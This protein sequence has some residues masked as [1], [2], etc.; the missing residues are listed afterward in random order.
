MILPWL[1]VV[2]L[3]VVGSLLTLLVA[4]L[5]VV[6]AWLWRREDREDLFREYVLLL[7][8][9]FAVLAVSRSV[10]H[11]VKQGLLL[12]D[13]QP[14]WLALS[15]YSGAVNTVSFV[16]AYGVSLSFQRFQTVN[17]QLRRH[18]DQLEAI[19]AERTAT[20]VDTN[21]HLAEESRARLQAM[22]QLADE[23]QRLTVTLR[24]I[25]DGVIATDTA[26]TVVLLNGIAEKLCGWEEKDA[27]GRPLTEVFQ[28]VDSRS[29][30]TVTNPVETVLATGELVELAN[31]V[32]LIS[33][34]G[35]RYRIADSGAPIVDLDEMII[36]AVLVFR[37]VSEKERLEEEAFR[38]QKLESL[39]VLAGGIA[40]DFNN[41]L[42]AIQGHVVLARYSL[43]G[44]QK[45]TAMLAAAETALQRA[46]GLARQLLT[47]AK[48]GVPVRTTMMLGDLVRESSD[49]TL[50]GANVRAEYNIADDLWPA[51]VDGGQISQ[52]IRNLVLN[53][54]QAMA[55][56]GVLRIFCGNFKGAPPGLSEGNWVRIDIADQ[57]PGIAADLQLRIFDPYFTTKKEGTGLGLA[58]CH[59]IVRK[60]DG[61]I[62]VESEA[63]KGSV[64]SV[65]LPAG[66]GTAVVRQAEPVTSHL[67]APARILVMDD[68]PMVVSV[69]RGM[70]EMLGHQVTVVEDGAAAVDAWLAAL[71]EG[72]GYDWGIF[73]LTVP[74][75][76]GGQ[77][78]AVDIRSRDQSAKLVVTSGYSDDPIMAD[79]GRFGFTARL[80]KPCQVK[81][82]HAIVG[83]AQ[84]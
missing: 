4:C 25:G 45:A 78:A 54:R 67:V 46:A 1:P 50:R 75:G 51:E 21:R 79:P 28:L 34:D 40:H 66:T 44:E 61:T 56:G 57:G 6:R 47:F 37:D 55:E 52:V 20:L 26:G 39:G 10:G 65:F 14:V 23:R 29:G 58:I 8:A 2:L 84:K 41:I 16:I 60:H 81:D 32:V 36:G 71:S 72:R 62:T 17:E 35:S 7:A 30:E 49:L 76:V 74:G 59:S 15:P 53:G 43:T 11:L 42:T 83:S 5:C 33:R 24:S 22:Q 9:G 73:D 3:D 38:A 18:R 63:G 48:G 80:A 13:M 64:F 19:V 70:L 69:L 31:H 27:L 68:E 77:Q 12:L 82:L